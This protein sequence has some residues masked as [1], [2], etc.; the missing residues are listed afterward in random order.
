LTLV[1]D[2]NV[3]VAAC[4]A[5]DGF[6]TYRHEALVAPP[7]LW[8][9]TRSALHA[10]AWRG[11]L[12]WPLAQESLEIL[13]SAPIRALAHERLGAEAW[14][15]ADELGWAK[16]YDAEYLALASLLDCTI[17][18]LDRRVARAASALGLTVQA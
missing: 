3:A 15:I 6:A 2:A 7:L 11:F 16:T 9:E 5:S 13:E 10:G 4:T 8:S 14:R 1:I 17:A 12:T 18:T